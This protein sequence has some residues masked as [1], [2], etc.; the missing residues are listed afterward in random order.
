MKRLGWPATARALRTRISM[1]S[2][3]SWARSISSSVDMPRAS[4][5]WSVKLSHADREKR[6]PFSIAAP[7]TPRDSASW[8]RTSGSS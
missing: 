1:F 2:P 8:S 3:W 4:M 7:L 5:A 6:L